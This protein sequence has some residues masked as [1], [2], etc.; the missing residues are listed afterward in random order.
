[1]RDLLG[2]TTRKD[3]VALP[4]LFVMYPEVHGSEGTPGNGPQLPDLVR[5]KG[6]GVRCRRNGPAGSHDPVEVDTAIA[7]PGDQADGEGR[8]RIPDDYGKAPLP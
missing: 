6:S 5:E 7:R 8:V 3:L 4:T 2:E 1:M